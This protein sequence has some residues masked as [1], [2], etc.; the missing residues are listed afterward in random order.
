[1]IIYKARLRKRNLSGVS[2]CAA[3]W[4]SCSACIRSLSFFLFF[5]NKRTAHR[6][7]GAHSPIR[8]F[9]GLGTGPMGFC[10]SAALEGHSQARMPPG[11]NYEICVAVGISREDAL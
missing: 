5:F 3:V 4:V 7:L 11:V 9:L 1:M 6:A 10:V 8:R 2:R